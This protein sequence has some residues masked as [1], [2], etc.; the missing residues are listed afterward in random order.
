MKAAP[1]QSLYQ[2]ASGGHMKSA[3]SKAALLLA[4]L[5][6]IFYQKTAL[7]KDQDGVV[8]FGGGTLGCAKNQVPQSKNTEIHVKCAIS[9]NII[10]DFK[11]ETATIC[12]GFVEGTW[13]RAE[14]DSI[15]KNKSVTNDKFECR[16]NKYDLASGFE[17]LATYDM[18][19]RSDSP[20]PNPMLLTYDVISGTVQ[21]CVVPYYDME[22]A[23]I[24]EKSPPTR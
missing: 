23:C 1:I 11:Q 5:C 14:Q 19:S 8:I 4:A 20:N 2:Q 12:T 22:M 18:S 13:I 15:Y 7:A 21:I 16:H 9:L 24:R 6:G 10:L 3:C 17:K